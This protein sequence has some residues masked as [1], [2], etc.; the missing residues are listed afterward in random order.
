VIGVT[1]Q[2]FRSLHTWRMNES[3]VSVQR[4]GE[5]LQD[6]HVQEQDA[7]NRLGPGIPVALHEQ[8]VRLI[9]RIRQDKQRLRGILQSALAE[10][11]EYVQW[12]ELQHGVGDRSKVEGKRNN[13]V[14]FPRRP[15]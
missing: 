2:C 8:I 12:T 7:L 15:L 13:L 4:V 10:G 5:Q 6:L 11:R 3:F 9:T 1:V 14:D